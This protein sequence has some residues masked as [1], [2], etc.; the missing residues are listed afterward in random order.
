MAKLTRAHEYYL[1]TPCL[2][3]SRKWIACAVFSGRQHL[4]GRVGFSRLVT[5]MESR[6][7]IGDHS[8]TM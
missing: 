4:N 3:K 1:I 6:A 2:H 8:V 7:A 5:I